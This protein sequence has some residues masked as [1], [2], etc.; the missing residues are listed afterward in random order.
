[1]K[2]ESLSNIENLV[3]ALEAEKD[4]PTDLPSGQTL[5]VLDLTDRVLPYLNKRA[6]ELINVSIQSTSFT[7]VVNDKY[8]EHKYVT[9]CLFACKLVPINKQGGINNI[10]IKKWGKLLNFLADIE[11]WDH[12]VLSGFGAIKLAKMK[13][14]FPNLKF[15]NPDT[16]GIFTF[17]HTSK[18]LPWIIGMDPSDTI[19][20]IGTYALNK[21]INKFI[22]WK[23]IM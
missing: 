4:T 23:V 9:D 16:F 11:I 14:N 8:G 12:G 18:N 1:M 21:K 6:K 3:A 20:Q 19:K 22:G 2:S 15:L 5:Q 7:E 17:F 13:G 10:Y